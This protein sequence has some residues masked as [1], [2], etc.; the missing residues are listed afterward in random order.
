MNYK[1]IPIEDYYLIV[2]GGN[3]Y[4]DHQEALIIDGDYYYPIAQSK[5]VHEGIPLF[6]AP[7]EW[8]LVDVEELTKKYANN[9]FQ[10][11]NYHYEKDTRITD[12]DAISKAF[13]S[14]YLK[15][16]ETHKWTDE[17][18]QK[19]FMAGAEF[20]KNIGLNMINPNL[21]LEEVNFFKYS[22]SLK[23]PKVYEV[24]IEKQCCNWNGTDGDCVQP[25]CY[26]YQPKIT[27]N[28]IN[29]LSW[30]EIKQL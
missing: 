9:N 7:K 20:A 30:E 27:N 24:Q 15:R 25:N 17:D 21:N 11:C 3:M 5:P 16:A 13:K 8:G 2:R 10:S 14:G 29:I 26:D 1:A 19:C 18:M 4:D 23:K 12:F 6:D 22:Q 28:K